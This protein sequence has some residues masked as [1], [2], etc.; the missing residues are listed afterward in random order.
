MPSG[1]DE[2]VRLTDIEYAKNVAP[3]LEQALTESR[4]AFKRRRDAE[5]AERAEKRAAEEAA[6]VKEKNDEAEGIVEAAEHTIRVGGTLGNDCVT[7]YRSKYDCSTYSVVNHLF[8]KYGISVPLRTQGWI[9][10]RLYDVEIKDGKCGS[11]RYQRSAR[12]RTTASTVFGTY[13]N[14]LIEAVTTAK[15]A[16]D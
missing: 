13:M 1:T 4:L 8:R 11:F 16:E 10:D 9:N 2:H 3:E 6:F 14:L 5:Y 12:S 7:F 15:K